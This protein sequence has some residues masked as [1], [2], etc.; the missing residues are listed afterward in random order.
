MPAITVAGPALL[1]AVLLFHSGP[2]DSIPVL[3]L[4]SWPADS[5][6][7]LLFHSC[8]ADL[9]AV[10]LFQLWPAHLIALLPKL[11]LASAFVDLQLIVE[12]FAAD[13]IPLVTGT[14]YYRMPCRLL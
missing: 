8:P 1:I 12:C 13:I 5:T 3:L 2:A 6:A 9:I 10:L 7:V 14:I 4:H 11:S